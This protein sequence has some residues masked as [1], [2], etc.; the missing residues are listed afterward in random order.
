L[1]RAAAAAVAL[2]GRL[3]VVGG[4][5]PNGLAKAMLVYDAAKRRWSALPGPTPRQHL[6][7]AA[8]RGRVY[9]IAGRAAGYDTNTALVESWA[10][11]EKRWRRERPIPEAR[12]GTAVATAAGTIVS[13][14]GE[15]PEGTTAAVFGFDVSTRR[16]R[17]L[18]DLP[19]ARHGL[20]AVTFGG[21]VY[22][23]AGGP[24]PGL[25]VTGANEVLGGIGT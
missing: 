11:G 18:P 5:G 4:V 3:Y 7:A 14:G 16:W 24:Q 23:L 8:A 17:R 21:R 10:P 9:V 1:P 6:S 25:T 15:A 20:G 12:G 13:V 19:T 2:N 22:V